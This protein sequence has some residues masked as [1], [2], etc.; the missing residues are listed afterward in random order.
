MLNEIQDTEIVIGIV[1][2][3]GTNLTAI[4]IAIEKELKV[5]EYRPKTITLSEA[6]KSLEH[7]NHL[8]EIDG[9]EF[10]RISQSMDAGDEF[11][12]K[13]ESG[14]AM[15][16]LG[17]AAIREFRKDQGEY[18]VPL[19]RQAYILRSLKRPE[20]IQELK[21]IYGDLFIVFSVYSPESD[22]INRLS[23]KICQSNNDTDPSKYLEKAKELI[24][25]D[26]SSG[27]KK[28]GQNVLDAFPLGDFFIC[29]S[30]EDEIR[31]QI[32]RF[33]ECW[34]GHP[35]HSPSKDEFGMYFANA[36]SLRSADLSRQVG[37]AILTKSGDILTV[38][39]NEV[40][41]KGGGISWEGEYGDFRDYKLGKDSNVN[42]KEVIIQEILSRLA[43]KGW[44]TD[45][46]SELDPIVRAREAIYSKDAPVDGT[47]VSS[48]LEFG[49]IVHAEMNALMDASKRGIAVEG[50]TLYC[51]T[52]P[53]HMCARHI[54]AAGIDR[55]VFIEPYSKSMAE[56]LY[57]NLISIDK[58]GNTED[59]VKFDA[60]VGIAPSKYLDMFKRGKRKKSDGYVLEWDEDIVKYPRANVFRP[61][62]LEAETV[63]VAKYL[64]H[65]QELFGL[66]NQD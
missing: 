24:E 54:I 21:K 61:A 6:L 5:L 19:E 64:Q 63:I 11:R 36:A 35:F 59:K 47:R 42:T 32:R 53:C 33:F 41:K 62:Y 18:D 51:T 52:F 3:V 49:R 65:I 55:V 7:F 38:G 25:R 48:L 40:P 50:A 66:Q 8:N 37:A 17:I 1:G 27:H 45:E 2:A 14:A 56:D 10:D 9:D 22:R 20:E 15:S 31:H 58:N 44:L 39:C 13:T 30:D 16:L 57:G 12:E 60:F 4:S 26:D 29:M 46:K 43:K 28:F 34:F 23:D